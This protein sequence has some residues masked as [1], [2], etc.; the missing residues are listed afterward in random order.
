MNPNN[1]SITN[2]DQSMDQFRLVQDIKQSKTQ[3]SNGTNM[4][5]HAS[6]F[7][8]EVQFLNSHANET[9]GKYHSQIRMSLND[10][11]QVQYKQESYNNSIQ[12]LNNPKI[13]LRKSFFMVPQNDQQGK[14]DINNLKNAIQSQRDINQTEIIAQNKNSVFLSP[15]QYQSYNKNHKISRNKRFFNSFIGKK[16]NTTAKISTNSSQIIQKQEGNLQQV[17][18]SPKKYDSIELQYQAKYSRCINER[19]GL[20]QKPKDNT[21]A[22]ASIEQMM[23]LR[24]A[25][26]SLLS[27]INGSYFNQSGVS[28]NITRDQNQSYQNNN[29]RNRSLVYDSPITKVSLNYRSIQDFDENGVLAAGSKAINSGSQILNRKLRKSKANGAGV[30][31]FLDKIMEVNKNSLI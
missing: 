21:F 19:Y 18:Q 24:K 22:P 14:L 12:Q 11:Q 23:D 7:T 26:N 20:S 5:E 25:K 31:S 27:Q 6:S 30:Q 2:Q 4:N 10:N 16:Q 8:K 9:L 3:K 29:S 17:S 28:T 15:D 13:N 1:T